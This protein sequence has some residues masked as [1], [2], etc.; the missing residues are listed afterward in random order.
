MRPFPSGRKPGIID[1]LGTGYEQ[2]NRRPWLILLPLLID[3]LLWRG[4]LVTPGPYFQGLFAAYF[5]AVNEA[6]IPV[7]DAANL[8]QMRQNAEAVVAGFNMLSLLVL[9][10]VASVPTTGGGPRAAT[11]AVVTI[12]N[13]WLFLGLLAVLELAG[14]LFGCIYYGLVAQQIRDGFIDPSRLLA[15]LGFY[16]KTVLT[17]ALLLLGVFVFAGLPLSVIA[18][19]LLLAGGPLAGPALGVFMGALYLAL[20]WAVLFLYFVIDAVVVSEVPPR[21]AILSSVSVVRGNFWST[22]AFVVLVFIITA[23]TQIIWSNLGDSAWGTIA[24]MVGNA[25]I[26]SGLTAA[27]MY[28]Y[29]DRLAGLEQHGNDERNIQR[30]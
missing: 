19:L 3:L 21:R 27:S 18:A 4:P 28:F 1:V 6:G 30:R 15:K 12:D 22:L 8:E 29:K 25:Y 14:L 2:I 13:G 17:L 26:A 10:F 20:L 23:G 5:R 7:E 11:A 9:N 24:G 16:F